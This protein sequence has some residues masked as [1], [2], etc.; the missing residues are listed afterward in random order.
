[1]RIDVTLNTDDKYC[2]HA[3]A[4]LCSLFEHNKEH[5]VYTHILINSLSDDNQAFLIGL[6]KRYNAIVTFYKVDETNLQNVK[7][8]ANRP[9]S[10]AAYYRI[11]LSSIL[12]ASIKTVLYLDCD[13]IVLDD[14]S[15][16][17]KLEIEDYALAASL[18]MFPLSDLH[19]RQLHIS[20][21]EK[22]FC[23]G[24]ML[25]NLDYWRRKGCEEKLIEYANRDRERVFYH[26]Q[27]ALNYVFKGKWFMIPPKW[28]RSAY[29]PV[30]Q[31]S[32]Y[33]LDFDFYE[34]KYKPKVIHYSD[35][36]MKPWLNCRSCNKRFYVEYLHKSNFPNPK[37]DKVPSALKRKCAT[38]MVVYWLEYYI[39]PYLPNLIRIIFDDIK[40]IIKLPSDIRHKTRVRS[41]SNYK[42]V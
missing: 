13:M 41:L 17:F 14:V 26:D 28:N 19:R 8:R 34:Y 4:M 33:Y 40:D 11:L 24:I 22:T 36:K 38:R 29:F 39:Y 37:F 21:G 25:I 12:D 15:D 30:A 7:F 5:T 6:G 23:S 20:V 9:L 35:A 27:D 16:L 10:K 32:P 42:R 31:N 1:M 18:D 2:Q 3:A